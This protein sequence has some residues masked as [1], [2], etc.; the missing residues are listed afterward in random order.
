VL[1]RPEVLDLGPGGDPGS[2]HPPVRDSTPQPASD[3]SNS[4]L[5]VKLRSLA[6]NP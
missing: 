4:I 6:K 3:S 5:A 1:P 2:Q